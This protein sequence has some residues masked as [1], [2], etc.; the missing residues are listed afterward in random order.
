MQF[1][2]GTEIVQFKVITS[3]HDMIWKGKI[4]NHSLGSIQNRK[5]SRVYGAHPT[6][7]QEKGNNTKIMD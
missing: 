3:K 4:R 5:R 1:V 7:E 2:Y 6:K